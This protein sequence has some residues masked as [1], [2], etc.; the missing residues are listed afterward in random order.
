[1]DPKYNLKCPYQRESEED[2]VKHTQNRRE[3]EDRAEKYLKV[4]DMARNGFF[5]RGFRKKVVLP[6][7]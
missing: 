5:P 3:Y 2:I 7:P 4:P 1:M 6:T